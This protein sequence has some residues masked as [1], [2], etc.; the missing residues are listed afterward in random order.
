MRLA[1]GNASLR[2][3]Y[4]KSIVIAQPDDAGVRYLDAASNLT[5]PACGLAL[6]SATLAGVEIHACRRCH[7]MLMAMGVLETLVEQMRAGQS[8]SEI[9]APPDPADL[10]R[11]VDCP[12]CR[13]R[14]DTH[15][16]YGGGSAVISGC[17]LCSLNW[18]DG[19]VLMRIVRAPHR[20]GAEAEV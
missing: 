15:F 20:D 5:C 10:N 16:Y 4:C 8:G 9:P 2:C 19:G 18:L 6:W 7:G 13:H 1:N 11:K 17:E 3:D 14:M 12:S